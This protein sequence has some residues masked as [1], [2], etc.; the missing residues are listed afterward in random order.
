MPTEFILHNSSQELY[1]VTL[2]A[3]GSA[4]W[5]AT[6]IGMSDC[7]AGMS[8][9]GLSNFHLTSCPRILGAWARRMREISRPD[10]ARLIEEELARKK[11]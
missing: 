5:R 8:Y 3:F 4:S 1:A 2:G 9:S 7:Y 6:P 10:C 11:V